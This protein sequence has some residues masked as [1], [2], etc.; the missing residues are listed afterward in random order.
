MSTFARAGSAFGALI[1]VNA[2]A[3]IDVQFALTDFD[4]L[5]GLNCISGFE[6]V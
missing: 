6:A 1:F 4:R 3:R 2:H 5:R